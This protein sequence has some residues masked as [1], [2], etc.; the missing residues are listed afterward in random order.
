[1]EEILRSNDVNRFTMVEFFL[2]H[3]GPISL[4]ETFQAHN[5]RNLMSSNA[6]FLFK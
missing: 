1:M 3:S 2:H 4:S 6:V 5:F